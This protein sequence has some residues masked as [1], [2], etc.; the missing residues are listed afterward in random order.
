MIIKTDCP[1]KLKTTLFVHR[2]H[3]KR[4]LKRQMS[5]TQHIE[6]SQLAKVCLVAYLQTAD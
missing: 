4:P 6:E 2:L 5:Q 1:Q 3:L